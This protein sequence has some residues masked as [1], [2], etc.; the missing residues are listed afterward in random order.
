MFFSRK[1]SDF[2]LPLKNLFYFEEFI[3]KKK[4]NKTVTKKKYVHRCSSRCDS[5]TET[6]EGDA[7]CKRTGLICLRNEAAMKSLN[8]SPHMFT[9]HC[10]GKKTY[11]IL[12]LLLKILEIWCAQTKG[13]CVYIHVTEINNLDSF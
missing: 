10:C 12:V 6:M 5:H 11:I 9:R 2:Q 3:L 8:I 1:K 13:H 7:L 4:N